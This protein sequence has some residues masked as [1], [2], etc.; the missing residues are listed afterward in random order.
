[1]RFG[2]KSTKIN[3]AIIYSALINSLKVALANLP[4]HYT[5]QN[6]ESEYKNN[7][8]KISSSTWDEKFDLPDGSYL[9]MDIQDYFEFIIKKHEK[10]SSDE[11][12]P[13]LIY[14]NRIRNR[15][16]LKIKT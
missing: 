7:K 12:F 1:M 16:V 4:I 14:P 13:V 6:V 2:G 8:F 5:W 15:I 9:I 10:I 11:S 3:S